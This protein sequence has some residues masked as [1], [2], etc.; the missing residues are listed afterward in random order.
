MN[1]FIGDHFR[2]SKKKKCVMFCCVVLL[3][4]LFCSVT[5]LLMGSFRFDRERVDLI[6]CNLISSGV[7]VHATFPRVPKH[8]INRKESR[9]VGD[10][11]TE[12]EKK[13]RYSC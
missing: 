2:H 8:S 12:K 10:E 5:D 9:V 3:R 13:T 4:H 7:H 1:N 11:P 6:R